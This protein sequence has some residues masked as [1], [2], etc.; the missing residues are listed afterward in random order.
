[1]FDPTQFGGDVT[2]CRRS[3]RKVK[4]RRSR[5]VV[6]K[7]GHGALR[8]KLYVSADD[9]ATVRSLFGEEIERI[10]VCPVPQEGAMLLWPDDGSGIY[11]TRTLSSNGNTKA[12]VL[13]IES[14]S[15]PIIDKYGEFNHVYL[16]MQTIAD[17]Q[18]V[19]FSPNGMR[20]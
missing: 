3:A 16:D 9:M 7:G 10:C 8:V 12:T 15:Q 19:K 4:N 18:A 20:D 11:A 2:V 14:M 17:G 13:S 5:F 1:M 6:H